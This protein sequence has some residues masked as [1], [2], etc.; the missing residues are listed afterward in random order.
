MPTP[1]RPVPDTLYVIGWTSQRTSDVTGEV[2]ITREYGTNVYE[3]REAAENV[4]GQI[5]AVTRPLVP[6]LDFEIVEMHRA[7]F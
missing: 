3:S 7:A 5:A 4:A 6:T 2:I 1:Q